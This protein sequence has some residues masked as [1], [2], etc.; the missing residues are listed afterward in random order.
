MA[1]GVSGA[2]RRIGIGVFAHQHR[3][4]LAHI[5][6][7]G[8]TLA[9]AQAGHHASDGDTGHIVKFQTIEHLTNDARRA[10]LFETQLGMR[11]DVLAQS[12]DLVAMRVDHATDTF[13][14]IAN[15][16]HHDSPDYYCHPSLTAF[17]ATTE[18]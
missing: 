6:D 15:I 10:E 13:L 1:A 16:S 8:T 9:S 14:E 7:G 18:A 3:V 17:W 4:H 12:N 11:S 5:G 2:S